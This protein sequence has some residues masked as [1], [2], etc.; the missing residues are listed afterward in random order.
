MLRRRGLSVAPRFL[1][2]CLTSHT[3]SPFPAP[4]LFARSVRISRTTRS[5]TL[6]V[7]GYVTG[8]AFALTYILHLS[9]A[10][11]FLSRGFVCSRAVVP[12]GSLSRSNDV[13]PAGI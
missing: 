9:Y 1:W 5:C 13:V 8:M 3:V 4:R 10:A 6:R 7:K 11:G 2:E 12:P